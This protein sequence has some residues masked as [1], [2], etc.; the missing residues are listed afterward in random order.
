ME[1]LF[2]IFIISVIILCKIFVK[3]TENDS[4]KIVPNNKYF[5][6]ESLT[7]KMYDPIY[8]EYWTLGPGSEDK[9]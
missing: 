8:A 2:L 4:E 6:E 9:F 5:E 7:S 1:I 3:S